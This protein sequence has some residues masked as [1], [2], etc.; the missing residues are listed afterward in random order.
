MS[1]TLSMEP[2]PSPISPHRFSKSITDI[3]EL[4]S[5]YPLPSWRV[6]CNAIHDAGENPA[7][8]ERI[9]SKVIA[10]QSKLYILGND[11]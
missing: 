10:K 8:A 11:I 3:T 4:I 9:A 6:L 2:R 1:I 7:L 5:G